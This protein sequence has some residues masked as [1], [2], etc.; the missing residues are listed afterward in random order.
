MKM[1]KETTCYKLMV[2]RDMIHDYSKKDFQE[3]G[4]TFGNFITMV[5]IYEN[6]GVTQAGLAELN[7][8]DRN[9]IGQIIDKL[10]KKK[11]VERVREENDRRAYRLYV[12][13]LGESIIEQ[14][15]D[16]A[17]NGERD[18]FDKITTQEQETFCDIL[19]KLLG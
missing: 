7:H 2:I 1:L 12:T 3:I 8:K 17:F 10:E 18:L 5:M 9:V 13:E 16:I 6:S 15:W 14:Y 11:Y 4:I 19:D